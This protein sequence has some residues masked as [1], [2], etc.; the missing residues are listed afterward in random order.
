MSFNFS[1]GL[2]GAHG[3]RAKSLK[4][5][6]QFGYHQTADSPAFMDSSIIAAVSALLGSAVGGLTLSQ[7]RSSTSATLRVV[8]CW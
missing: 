4:F 6:Q 7:R 2:I 3:G 5:K 1:A 8:R